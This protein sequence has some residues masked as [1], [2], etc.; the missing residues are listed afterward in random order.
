VVVAVAKTIRER[1]VDPAV[2]LVQAQTILYKQQV[3]AIHR[4]QSLR[5]AIQVESVLV[6]VAVEVVVPV[7][8]DLQA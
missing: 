8:Q 2:E 5:R 3:R 7:A 6:T 1:Q 4:P